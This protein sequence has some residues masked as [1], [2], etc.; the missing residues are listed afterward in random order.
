MIK[1][2]IKELVFTCPGAGTNFDHT[3]KICSRNP[4]VRK[5]GVAGRL[6]ADGEE[7]VELDEDVEVELDDEEELAK[8]D[9]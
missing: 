8:V 1:L 9:A 7:E 6:E 5:W 2:G 3:M 4:A